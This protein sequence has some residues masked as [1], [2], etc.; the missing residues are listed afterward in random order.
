MLRE[1]S[2]EMAALRRL[3]HGLSDAEAGAEPIAKV[4][5]IV[6]RIDRLE[7]ETQHLR[8]Q[9]RAQRN[10]QKGT[11]KERAKRL[12]RNEVLRQI[13][14]GMNPIGEG[15]SVDVPKVIDMGHGLGIEFTH[16][17]VGDAFQALVAEWDCFEL[18]D[19]SGTKEGENKR[20]VGA[21]ETIPEA[22]WEIYRAETDAKAT[23]TDCF[24]ESRE[25]MNGGR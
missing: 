22:L 3:L 1:G 8:A 25:S 19:G 21:N 24:D 13:D 2:L 9:L 6:E 16:K 15:G 5:A 14:R 4:D 10:Q 12:A 11:K 18:R 17:T 20:L 7:T 23:K